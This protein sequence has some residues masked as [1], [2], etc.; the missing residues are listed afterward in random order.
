MT[1]RVLLYGATGFSGGLLIAPLR[2]MGL[3]VVLAGRDAAKLAPLARRHGLAWRAFGLGPGMLDEAALADA[4]LVLHCA[5]PFRETAS[6]MMAACI[7]TGTHYLDLAGEWPVFAEAMR[8][9]PEAAAAG[10]ML[11]PGVGYTLVASDC[12]LALAVARVPDVVRL[13]LAISEFALM[14]RGTLRSVLGQT[15]PT[16]LVRRRGE[17]QSLPVGQL[18]RRFD[19]GAGERSAT[20]V[21]WPDVVTAQFTTGVDTIE[22][23]AEVDRGMDLAYRT[24]AALAPLLAAAPV[25]GLLRQLS[26]AWPEAP[27]EAAR[28][29]AG[30]VTLVEAEDRWRRPT[31]LRLRSRDGYS[32]TARTAPE[33][34]RRVAAGEHRPGFQTPGRLFGGAFILGL[35]CAALEP[36]PPR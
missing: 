36:G 27:S 15:S 28:R 2:A 1:R 14:S 25:Q 34:A 8:R 26:L 29:A 22:A 7:R 30:L 13:R 33:I 17:L 6:A 19:F 5:G 11:M 9:G 16:V 35:G 23:F 4:A 20:A 21:T 18:T 31:T 24:G 10:V 32:V 12:L 3:D